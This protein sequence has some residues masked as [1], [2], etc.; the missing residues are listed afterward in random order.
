MRI[1]GDKLAQKYKTLPVTL[2]SEDETVEGL[3]EFMENGTTAELSLFAKPMKVGRTQYVVSVPVDDVESITANNSKEIDFRVNNPKIRVLYVEG[4]PRYE[5][6]GIVSVLSSDPNVELTSLINYGAGSY[7]ALGKVIKG[8]DLSKGLPQILS[9]YENFDIV[10]LG[11]MRPTDLTENQQKLLKT[12]V[13]DG[14]KL[15]NKRMHGNLL[16]LGG[17]DSL[18]GSWADSPLEELLPVELPPDTSLLTSGPYFIEISR[19]GLLSSICNGMPAYFSESDKLRTFKKLN[20]FERIKPAAESLIKASDRE[21]NLHHVV[22]V[23]NAG[24]KI[25]VNGLM[26]TWKPWSFSLS[27]KG[28]KTLFTVFWGQL[29]RWL[30]GTKE[31]DVSD[32]LT[33]VLSEEK[34]EPGAN[35]NVRVIVKDKQDKFIDNAQIDATVKTPQKQD[36]TLEFKPAGMPGQY[37]TQFL[38]QFVGKYQI[39]C[40]AWVEG[41]KIGEDARVFNV[42]Q[43][44]SEFYKIGI[45]RSYLKELAARNSGKYFNLV[46]LEKLPEA[47]HNVFRQ[48]KARVQNPEYSANIPLFILFVLMLSTEWFIRR[49]L[50]II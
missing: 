46:T 19:E 13:I 40:S 16:F 44:L 41:V 33:I 23:Q 12:W 7:T 38:P 3:A 47:L 50:H 5:F 31:E 22:V 10:I 2:K 14:I 1:S 17:A 26:E 18:S 39:Q 20:G 9:E 24:G 43:E 15:K 28:G 34:L 42:G 37:S 48:D 4:F 11:D 36:I 32:T 8:I 25:A 35:F 49:K 30:S 27:A 29:I 45:D 21:G 6:K